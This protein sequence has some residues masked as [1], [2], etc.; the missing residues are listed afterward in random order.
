[1]LEMKKEFDKWNQEKK[2]I[3]NNEQGRFYH[4]REIWWC[5]L[6]VNVGFE[7]DGTN[8]DFQRPVLVLKGFSRHVCLVVPLTTS[9]K[10]NKYHSSVGVINS[11]ESF[12]ITSQLRLIDTRRFTDRLTVLDKEIFDELRKTIRGLI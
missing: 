9:K 10:K 7:Q 5:S 4:E 6:G 12:I 3:H 11:E 1:M 8:K 2:R